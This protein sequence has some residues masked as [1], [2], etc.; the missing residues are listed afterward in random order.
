MSTEERSL[1]ASILV[2]LPSSVKNKVPEVKHDV[3]SSATELNQF[4]FSFH[5]DQCSYNIPTSPS[6]WLPAVPT[7]LM[8]LPLVRM[9]NEFKPR[10]FF[11]GGGLLWVSTVAC[12]LLVAARGGT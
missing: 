5:I 3:Q 8:P 7:Y 9:V 11:F 4:G 1:W 12:E 2:S 10:G 6:S